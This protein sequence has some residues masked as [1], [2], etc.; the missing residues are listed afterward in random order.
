MSFREYKQLD[1]PGMAAEVLEFWKSEKVFEKSISTRE[2]GQPFVFYEG[3]PSANGKPGIHHVIGR[4]DPGMPPRAAL[5]RPNTPFSRSSR[6]IAL[7]P[8]TANIRNITPSPAAKNEIDARRLWEV[9]E[10]LTGVSYPL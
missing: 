2:Q 3:P 6:R 1:L 8:V 7:R 9:S 10:K 4:D 5:R